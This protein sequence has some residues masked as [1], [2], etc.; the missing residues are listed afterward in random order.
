MTE[1]IRDPDVIRVELVE[2]LPPETGGGVVDVDDDGTIWLLL[3]APFSAD[4]PEDIDL[5][6]WSDVG[7]A[8]L[9]GGEPLTCA[10]QARRFGV[11]VEVARAAFWATAQEWW[12]R[13]CNR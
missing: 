12:R 5:T 1:I 4:P 8:V 9:E 2:S 3:E 11:D 13:S 7:Y 6:E 10:D